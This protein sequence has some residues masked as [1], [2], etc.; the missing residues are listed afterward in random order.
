MASN[1]FIANT[2]IIVDNFT[3][4]KKFVPGKFVHFISHFHG[5]HY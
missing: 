5:D 1:G 2:N 4:A 3:M